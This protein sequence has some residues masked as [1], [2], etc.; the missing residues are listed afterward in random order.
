MGQQQKLTLRSNILYIMFAE[1][2]TV[3]STLTQAQEYGIEL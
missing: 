2:V 1:A 3:C